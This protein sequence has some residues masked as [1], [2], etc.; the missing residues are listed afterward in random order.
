MASDGGL[1]SDDSLLGTVSAY[2]GSGYNQDLPA[3]TQFCH[4]A[5]KIIHRR[6]ALAGKPMA[7]GPVIFVLEGII[8]PSAEGGE[9]RHLFNMGAQSIEGRLWTGASRLAVATGLDLPQG[10]AADRFNYVTQTLGMGD[11]P[12]IYY[13]ASESEHLMRAFPEGMG[14]PNVYDDLSLKSADLSLEHIRD[15][16]KG[17]H[18]RLLVSPTASNLARSL[19]ENQQKTIPIMHAEKAVQDILHVALTARLGFGAIAVRQEGTSEMGRFDFHLE[20]QDPVDP[21]VWTHHAIIEL[22]VLKSFTSSG[23]PVA[24]RENLEAVTKG[25]KQAVGYRHAHKCRLAA[26]SCYDMRKPPDPEAAIAH[27]VSNAATWN[28]GL[29]AWPLYP[30]ADRARD[31]LVN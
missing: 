11:S 20:E 10:T 14:K 30:T 22:K 2:T 13:D 26:L 29:W 25:V 6:R 9:V 16:L 5:A 28:V 1:W 4:E 18:A 17:A 15:M 19:W 3:F 7:D 21:S 31:A 8:P 23:K 24:A 12:A 27:E